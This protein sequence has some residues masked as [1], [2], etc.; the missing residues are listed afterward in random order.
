MGRDTLKTDYRWVI[1]GSAL[2]LVPNRPDLTEQIRI[3][4][5]EF[6]WEDDAKTFLDLTVSG[7]GYEIEKIEYNGN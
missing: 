3:R 5:A 7:Y 2:K 1:T 4:I 6:L